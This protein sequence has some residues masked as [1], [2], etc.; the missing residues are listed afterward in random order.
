M[1]E[2]SFYW[3][4]FQISYIDYYK[5]QYSIDIKDLDQPLLINRPKIKSASE[6]EVT[7]LI[8]L[9]PE[10]CM[11]TGMTDTMRSDFRIMKE[12]TKIVILLTEYE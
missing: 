11:M 1:V 4:S 2:L 7:K 6:Q 10:L 8:C 12:V 5:R 3:F 9:I